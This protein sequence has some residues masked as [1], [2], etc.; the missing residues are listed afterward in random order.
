MIA[1]YH[2]PGMAQGHIT[3]FGNL[4]GH[5]HHNGF[6]EPF[7]PDHI[8][9]F[10]LVHTTGFHIEYNQLGGRVLL[11]QAQQILHGRKNQHI[12]ARGQAKGNPH[13]CGA[14]VVCHGIDHI[15][16]VGQD[17]HGPGFECLFRRITPNSPH[18]HLVV[19]ID[20]AQCVAAEQVYVGITA[21]MVNLGSDL[22]G[23]V[24]GNHKQGFHTMAPMLHHLL[25]LAVHGLRGRVDHDLVGVL[26]PWRFAEKRL[27][28][29]IHANGVVQG[30]EG[31]SSLAQGP[32]P[33]DIAAVVLTVY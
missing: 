16:G 5:I 32:A 8:Q 31:L 20:H 1:L 10:M 29:G 7:L 27:K 22:H 28:G 13:T 3:F 18:T 9:R 12:L 11:C 19:D 14:Q 26:L 6:G 4:T 17:T 24:F 23:H 21:H 15:A 2:G 33:N 25:D 30:L